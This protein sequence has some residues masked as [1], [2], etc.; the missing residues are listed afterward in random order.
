MIKRLILGFFGLLTILVVLA[1]F[2]GAR[3]L[4]Y[5]VK[6]GVNTYAPRI[7]QTSVYLDEV[8][9]SPWNGRGTVRN[10]TVGNPEGFSEQNA[11]QLGEA[12]IAIKPSSLI[13]SGPII[14]ERIH[15]TDP[16][17]LLEQAGGTTNLQRIQRN[18]EQATRTDVPPEEE[19]SPLPDVPGPKFIVRDFV[20]EGG[21]VSVSALGART[22][23]P[24][25]RLHLENIGEAEGGIGADELGAVLLSAIT[26][27]A[28]DA[29]SREVSGLLS[30]PNRLNESVRGIGDQIQRIFRRST[31]E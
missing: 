31:D 10:L 28:I 4:D 24:M 15:I 19:P 11:F 14:I 1:V 13:G 29:A 3:L 26:R 16:N 23:V 20:F 22:T 17:I 2:F 6:H 5:S 7:T 18:V 21:Q 9:L 30:D 12:T 8:N 25:P 27:A